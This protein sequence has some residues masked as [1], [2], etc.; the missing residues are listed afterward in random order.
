MNYPE[1]T[2]EIRKIRDRYGNEVELVDEQDEGVPY[3]VLA[4]FRYE[5]REYAVLQSEAMRKDGEVAV[6]RI[7]SEGGE[8]ELEQ[9]DDDDEWETVSE[10]ADEMTFAS[11]LEQA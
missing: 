11:G 1:G 2:Q 3:R 6:Y 9:I 8:P 10:L 5:G 7:R 4:E